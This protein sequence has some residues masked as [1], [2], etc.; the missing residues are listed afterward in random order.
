MKKTLSIISLVLVTA[1]M[2]V[3]L[4]SCGGLSGKY[5]AK[6][7]IGG[8]SAEASYEFSGDTYTYKGLMTTTEGKYAVEDDKIF[9]WDAEDGSKEDSVGVPFNKGSDDNGSYIEIA[10]VKYYKD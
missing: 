1:I 5:V 4:V 7:G 2:T 3:M 10:G 9:F 6:A 8:L